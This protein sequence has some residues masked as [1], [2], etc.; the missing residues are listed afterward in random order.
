LVGFLVTNFNLVLVDRPLET[1]IINSLHDVG[2]GPKIFETDM[3]KYRIEE[4]IDNLV[5]LK[6]DDMFKDVIFTQIAD[7]F[8]TYNSLGEFNHYENIVAGK[9]KKHFWDRLLDDS[10]TNFLNFTVKKMIPLAQKS[11][12]TFSKIA[13]ETCSDDG[14]IMNKLI[15]VEYYMQN[16]E[17]IFFDCTP[18]KCIMVLSHN[19]AH[20][21][22][23]M[24]NPDYS[25]V[26]VFDHEYASYNFLGF[27]IANY[28]L[29]SQFILEHTEFPFYQ[30]FVKDYDIYNDE[31]LFNCYL[32]FFDQF[33]IKK[34]Y[35]FKQLPGFEETIKLCKTKDYYFRMMGLSA[36]MWFVFGVI[37]L[38][39]ESIVNKT[40][41]DYF[42]YCLD[43][44]SIY[45]KFVKFQITL[46][47]K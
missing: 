33:L 4:Y 2:L 10:K 5:T 26:F 1:F 40:S 16:F 37:Y 29:E 46:A 31:R 7:I 27:D 44:K 38:D 47:N 23:I 45:S 35:L 15:E 21:L 3:D 28:I 20:I 9:S 43:R 39:F 24:H 22:N 12:D 6:N 8:T 18:E 42:N 25:K 14:D 34:G 17:K 32:M 41:F 36:L 11:L 30:F 13:R 19:D